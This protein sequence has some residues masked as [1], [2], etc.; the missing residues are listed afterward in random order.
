MRIPDRRILS[1]VSSKRPRPTAAGGSESGAGA[2]SLGN[3]SC[4]AHLSLVVVE[5]ERR[6]NVVGERGHLRLA[7]QIAQ[8][9]KDA[10]AR[11]RV[12][13]DGEDDARGERPSREGAIGKHQACRELAEEEQALSVVV[14]RMV[15]VWKKI[16]AVRKQQKFTS[17]SVKLSLKKI[18]KSKIQQG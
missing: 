14:A 5:H 16:K 12:R 18:N 9:R 11:R 6:L 8:Q 3:G 7:E 2:C 13:R 15:Q 17:T 10:L 4:S 1:S